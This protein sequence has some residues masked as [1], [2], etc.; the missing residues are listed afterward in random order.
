M[1]DLRSHRF[2][3][4]SAVDELQKPRHT[5]VNDLVYTEYTAPRG[6]VLRSLFLPESLRLQEETASFVFGKL[7]RL[8]F[9]R[10]TAVLGRREH[11][12]VPFLG[13]MYIFDCY[14][15]CQS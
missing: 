9:S 13:S 3:T 4:A 1:S 10:Y 8:R 5:R 12:P 11:M 14:S 2:S 7:A 15:S 6:V